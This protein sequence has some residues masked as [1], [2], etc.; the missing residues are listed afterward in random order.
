M[1][2]YYATTISNVLS[3]VLFTVDISQAQKPNILIADIEQTQTRKHM[4][5]TLAVPR[6]ATLLLKPGQPT[7]NSSFW[8]SNKILQFSRKIFCDNMIF[9]TKPFHHLID[10]ASVL[11]FILH[12]PKAR[13]RSA[14]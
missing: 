4:V 14:I 12:H 5:F 3:I 8:S 6:I 11:K 9:G 7:K 13:H 10:I 2:I 1:K